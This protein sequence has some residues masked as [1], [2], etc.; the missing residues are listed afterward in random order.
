[1]DSEYREASLE[2][3]LSLVSQSF[4]LTERACYQ[5]GNNL[6]MLKWLISYSW[7]QGVQMFK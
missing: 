6:D 7:N 5:I 4:K 3:R 1:L 2:E